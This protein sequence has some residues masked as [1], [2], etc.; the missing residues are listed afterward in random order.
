M[1]QWMYSP[2]LSRYRMIKVIHK[3]RKAM[4]VVSGRTSR[5]MEEVPRVMVVVIAYT[6]LEKDFSCVGS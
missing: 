5:V 6:Y 2:G 4:V 1:I 3:R